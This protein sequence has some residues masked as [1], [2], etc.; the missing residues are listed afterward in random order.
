MLFYA[1]NAQTHWTQTLA[2]YFAIATKE[3]LF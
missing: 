2:D 3:G 1:L